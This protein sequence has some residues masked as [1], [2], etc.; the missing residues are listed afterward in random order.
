MKCAGFAELLSAFVDEENTALEQQEA[1]EHLRGCQPCRDQ[2]A[3]MRRLKHAI[4]R[5]SS[6]EDPPGSV[7]VRVEALRFT[8]AAP[9]FARKTVLLSCAAILTG[10]L[11][12]LYRT[13]ALPAPDARLTEALVHDHVRSA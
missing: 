13:R 6:R 2:V 3:S 9:L 4:A 1:Q 8:T 10:A 12:A 5:L 11:L 7:R